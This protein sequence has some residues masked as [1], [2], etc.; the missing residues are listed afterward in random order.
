MTTDLDTLVIARYVKIDD[1]RADV[2]RLPERPPKLS[3]SE[4]LCLAVMQAML[5]FHS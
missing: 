2:A 3:H 5:G 1:D 4:L